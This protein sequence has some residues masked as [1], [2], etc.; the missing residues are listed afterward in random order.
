MED[1]PYPKLLQIIRTQAGDQIP[2]TF[3]FGTVKSVSPLKVE[4]SETV[5][6][7]ADL[8]KNAAIGELHSGDSILLI[9]FEED[10]RFI[11]LCKLVSV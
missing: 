8:L 7:A 3:R 6:T 9:P 1:N 11:M 5:Q 2:A 4:V 10:Q